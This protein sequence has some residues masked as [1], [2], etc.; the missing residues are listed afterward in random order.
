MS[1]RL[2]FLGR[3]RQNPG[4]QKAIVWLVKKIDMY[5]GVYEGLI[6]RIFL[7]GLEGGILTPLYWREYKLPRRWWTFW[8]KIL[9]LMS[10][11]FLITNFVFLHETGDQE[12][13]P[14]VR[15]SFQSPWKCSY[16]FLTKS[17]NYFMIYMILTWRKIK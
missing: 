10:A 2:D 11:I 15:K 8:T 17:D 13:T 6:K 12:T 4:N 1:R 3:T 5:T 14:S 7:F 9:N 16:R